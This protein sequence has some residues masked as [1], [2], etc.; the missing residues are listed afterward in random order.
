MNYCKDC[1]FCDKNNFSG[2]QNISE[3][4]KCTKET[5][6]NL[7]NGL[8]GMDYCAAARSTGKCGPDGMLFMDRKERDLDIK[9]EG[10]TFE[11]LVKEVSE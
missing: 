7:V 3:Y 1:W 5:F 8:V 10:G 2:S 9:R 11:S 4:W 6:T